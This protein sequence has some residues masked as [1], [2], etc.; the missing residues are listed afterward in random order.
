MVQ[1]GADNPSAAASPEGAEWKVL[2][3]GVSDLPGCFDEDR[4]PAAHQPEVS[5]GVGEADPRLRQPV[6]GRGSQEGGDHHQDGDAVLPAGSLAMG[7]QSTGP[8]VRQYA[9]FPGL[10]R[11]ALYLDDDVGGEP[12]GVGEGEESVSVESAGLDGDL[13]PLFCQT[14]SGRQTAADGLAGLFQHG[15]FRDM[16]V[17]LHMKQ[18]IF[19]NILSSRTPPMQEVHALP[20][21]GPSDSRWDGLV[22]NQ[23]GD[24]CGERRATF[25]PVC[26]G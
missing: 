11:S 16:D 20:E 7:G 24:A 15:C 17:P 12:L 1:E 19:R 14:P 9:D 6:L 10:H 22:G 26:L 8:P 18:H 5:G 3:P 25:C 4:R 2:P 13:L 23:G 21:S